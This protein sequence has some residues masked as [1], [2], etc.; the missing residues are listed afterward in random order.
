MSLFLSVHR[1]FDKLE[2]VLYTSY[3]FIN[4]IKT[5]AR[6]L[7]N[8]GNCFCTLKFSHLVYYKNSVTEL[9]ICF[10]QNI[11]KCLEKDDR[12]RKLML[13]NYNH[14]H[15]NY[16]T[17]LKARYRLTVFVLSRKLLL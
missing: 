11:S 12:L 14:I 13:T 3:V 1:D 7:R 6:K 10:F 8:I 15:N 4:C 2:F 9:N 16:K 17:T 5:G